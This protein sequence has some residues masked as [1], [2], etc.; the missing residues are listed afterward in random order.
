MKSTCLFLL[1]LSACSST[2]PEVVYRPV[3]V[4][5]PLQVNCHAPPIAPPDWPLTQLSPDVPLQQSVRAMLAEI[6][7]HK[8]YEA[9]LIAALQACM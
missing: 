3:S 8:A 4:A 5:T 1:L 7:R 9:Q 2:P 6:D